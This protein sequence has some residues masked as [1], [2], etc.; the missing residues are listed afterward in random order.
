MKTPKL[1]LVI[2]LVFLCALNA[3][4]KSKEEKQAEAR[5]KADQTLARLYKA[6][7]SAQAAIKKAA[8]Y[9]VFNSAGVKILVAGGGKGNGIAV[10]N[11]SQKVTYMKM[12]E[13][14]AGLGM[15]AKKFST[16]FVFETKEALEKFINSGWEFGGQTT[17]AAKTGDGGG[18]YQGAASVSEG[19]WMYQL[20][21]KGLALEL[22]GKGTKYFKD[23]D[24]NK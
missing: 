15:G 1:P 14:Q 10:D 6:K 24:L 11:A 12:R 8:G 5:K 9:A 16:I 20:T 22:T 23:D 21:D 2:S 4:A 19:V 13:V 18:S 3:A 17:A 7:P